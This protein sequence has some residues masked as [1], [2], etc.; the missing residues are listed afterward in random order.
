MNISVNVSAHWEKSLGKVYRNA[1]EMMRYMWEMMEMARIVLFGKE[2]NR[3]K[4][5][6]W[7][8]KSSWVLFFTFL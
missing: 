4:G 5:K 7:N 6:C 3:G 1:S 2:K 8:K